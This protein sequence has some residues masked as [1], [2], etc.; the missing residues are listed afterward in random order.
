MDIRRIL[1]LCYGTHPA[2]RRL[3]FLKR[4]AMLHNFFVCVHQVLVMNVNPLLSMNYNTVTPLMHLKH[5]H[6]VIT[7]LVP[8]SCMKGIFQHVHLLPSRT[9]HQ[10]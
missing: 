8:K 1:E 9:K 4:I 2:E 6:W 5:A 7:E 3:T 10:K